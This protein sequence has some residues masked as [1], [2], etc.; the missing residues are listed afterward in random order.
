VWRRAGLLRARA[1]DDKPHYLFEPSGAD[2]P[3]RYKWKGLSAWARRRRSAPQ[4]TNEVQY[5]A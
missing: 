1:A 4:P 5:E 2:A 3:R